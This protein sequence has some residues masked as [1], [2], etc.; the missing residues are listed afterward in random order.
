MAPDSHQLQPAW[1]NANCPR[2]G[3]Y[4]VGPLL[5]R[6]GMGN[7]HE[8]WDVV[9]CRRVALKILKDIEPPALI[10]F[11][12]EA[13]IHARVVHPNICRIYDVDNYQ[14]ALRVAMQLVEG[15]NL[16]QAWRDLTAKEA[17]TIMALVAQAVH[18]VHR[19][20]LVHRD[21]KP[22]NI[23]LERNAE[24]AWTPYVCDFGLAMA[25]DEP[26]LTYSHGVMG[27]PAYMAPEQFHGERDRIS[28]ATD[29]YALGGT[30][31][32]A[33]TGR[34]PSTVKAPLPRDGAGPG[35]PR[36]LKL[37]IAKCM[38]E[39]PDLRYPSAAALAEDLWRFR[40]GEPIRAAILTPL[41]HLAR[42]G[43]KG[44]RDIRQCKP[45]LLAAAT[46]AA[47][48]IGFPVY[49][50]QLQRWHRQELAEVRQLALE[51]GELETGLRLERTQAIHDLRPTYAR[52]RSRMDT[53]RAR[54]RG[55]APEAQ[56]QA[57]YALG[58]AAYLLYDFQG[59][60]AELEQA[61]A[62]GYQAPEAAQLLASAV[63]ARSRRS[64]QAAQFETGLETPAAPEAGGLDGLLAQALAPDREADEYST[65]LAASLR[66][67]YL[68]GATSSHAY[69]LEAPWRFDAAILEAADLSALAQESLEAGEELKA[70]NR[71]QEA[72]GVA[73][74]ALKEDTSD[75]AL[76]HV[77][78]QAARGLAGIDLDRGELPLDWLAGFQAQCTE[79]LRLDPGDPALQDDWLGLRWLS[80][81]R[82]SDLGQDPL[83]DLEAAMV[84]LGTRV[85]EPLT[86]PLRADRMIVYWQAAERSFRRGAD[87]EPA[88]SEALKT[89]GHTPFLFRDYFWE[90]L[91]FKARA[92][93]T[94]GVDPRPAL[95]PA[96]D[97]LQTQLMKGAPWS[98][99][100][101]AAATWLIRAEWEASHGLDARASLENARNQAESARNQN[102][103]D[104]S[105]YALEGLT[106]ALEV[107]TAPWK[108]RELLS[109]AQER[110][111][112]SLAL[113]F[114]GGLQS[115][116]KAVLAD[117]GQPLP[118]P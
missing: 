111:R 27:T 105:A 91:N 117:Q 23:L 93:A 75:Q 71:Y 51:T 64:R 42:I 29:V 60:A 118:R 20:N 80:A 28:A 6:G 55:L 21:L 10:R 5:G 106:R 110:L 35:L 79:A 38:E 25:L 108:K 100:A 103:G 54:A 86:A 31:H 96:L 24:G 59:A 14:G 68:R 37:V 36:D 47:A 97:R 99:R 12:H 92:E 85:R 78:F 101:T 52:V 30:L 63:L 11:M 9:L 53:W 46:I 94:R 45:C 73:R 112:L 70:R 57:H 113:G 109:Q 49:H 26:A 65:A 8:A 83:P 56:A 32:F 115:R 33:L 72:L 95:D 43:R 41:S 98:L 114:G 69:F 81:M 19:L 67:E 18:V 62:G 88:L 90:V 7:V 107:Q 48:A 16:E 17:V 89:S 82:R 104:A 39:D 87:P 116:L 22:S 34:P 13:Q 1:L 76:Y 66:A 74:Q 50:A 2:E 40:E 61:W 4:V 44:R 15:S 58:C 84:F 77:Y 3:R 102:P